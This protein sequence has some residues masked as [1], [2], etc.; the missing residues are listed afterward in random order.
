MK[1]KSDSD[2]AQKSFS[3]NLETASLRR[4]EGGDFG[5][6]G[7]RRLRAGGPSRLLGPWP[8]AGASRFQAPAAP[9]D[10]RGAREGKRPGLQRAWRRR[11]LAPRDIPGQRA[12]APPRAPLPGAG[13]PR[14]APAQPPELRPLASRPSSGRTHPPWLSSSGPESLRV[15]PR[16]SHLSSGTGATWEW[17]T[18]GQTATS[19]ARW[20]WRQSGQPRA[21][22]DA[23]LALGGRGGRGGTEAAAFQTEAE[24]FQAFEA[25]HARLSLPSLPPSRR[26]P[27]C[28]ELS[29]RGPRPP[30][31]GAGRMPQTCPW[32]DVGSHLFGC[33]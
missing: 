32:Q 30:L 23:E 11:G 26:P 9:P 8:S 22:R 2:G 6:R 15:S 20:P 1:A 25:A 19:A 16:R 13:H 14:R 4:G 33:V 17:G 21:G 3:R 24:L 10:R 27:P 18:W 5:P 28:K 29:A 7:G 31:P 12:P